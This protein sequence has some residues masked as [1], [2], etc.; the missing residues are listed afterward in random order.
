M[1]R[2]AYIFIEV[3]VQFCVTF[4]QNIFFTDILFYRIFNYVH[5][6]FIDL[7]STIAM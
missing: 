1:Y 2:I 5:I 4:L 7:K 6:F 3:Y